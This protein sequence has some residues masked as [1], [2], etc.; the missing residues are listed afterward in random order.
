VLFSAKKTCNISETGQH[1]TKVTI[2]H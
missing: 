2:E 1:R